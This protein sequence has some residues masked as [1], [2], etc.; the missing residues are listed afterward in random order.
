MSKLRDISPHIFIRIVASLGVID[1]MSGPKL[2][3]EDT[4]NISSPEDGDEEET[5]VKV[6]KVSVNY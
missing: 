4:R 3:D 5:A 2:Q 1:P 6:P